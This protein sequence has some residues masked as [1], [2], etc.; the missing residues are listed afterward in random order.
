[1]SN[2]LLPYKR[3]INIAPSYWPAIH[4]IFCETFPNIVHF[5]ILWW[6]CRKM[7]GV[8]SSTSKQEQWVFL[9]FQKLQLNLWELRWLCPDLRH[10]RSFKAVGLWTLKPNL[11]P[12]FHFMFYVFYLTVLNLI[13]SKMNLRWNFLP[14]F[15]YPPLQKT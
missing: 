12:V 9:Q 13:A 3:I 10:V 5:L 4:N 14:F 2:L 8:A 7:W 6:Q 15:S 1:M 11:W